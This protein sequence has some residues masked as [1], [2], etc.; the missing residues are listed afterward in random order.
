LS[1]KHPNREHKK[2]V[3]WFLDKKHDDTISH[4]GDNEPK[5]FPALLVHGWRSIAISRIIG[6]SGSLHHVALHHQSEL[7]VVEEFLEQ[8]TDLRIAIKI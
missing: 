5:H 1:N 7:P 4:N 3:D 8:Q 2:G 6:Q